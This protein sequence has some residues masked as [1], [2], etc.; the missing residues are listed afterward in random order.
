MMNRV[1]EELGDHD[2]GLTNNRGVHVE[3]TQ[4]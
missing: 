1:G 2:L 4:R 3:V